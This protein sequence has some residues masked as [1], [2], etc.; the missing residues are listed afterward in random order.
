MNSTHGSTALAPR[1][2]PDMNTPARRTAC[3]FDAA[4]TGDPWDWDAEHAN[5]NTILRYR[6]E[7]EAG[8]QRRGA[9]KIRP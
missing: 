5:D 2:W 3:R 4:L 9:A 6:W 7:S 8:D 1:A